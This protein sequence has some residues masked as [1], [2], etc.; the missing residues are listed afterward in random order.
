MMMKI[1]V[2]MPFLVH[3]E[4]CVV[5]NEGGGASSFRSVAKIYNFGHE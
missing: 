1:I 2:S 5:R 4:K 3:R